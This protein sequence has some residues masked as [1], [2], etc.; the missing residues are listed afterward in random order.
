MRDNSLVDTGSKV[1]RR[2]G[3]ERAV[4][5]RRSALVLAMLFKSLQSGKEGKALT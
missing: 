5:D 4:R 2:Y 1:G 3:K